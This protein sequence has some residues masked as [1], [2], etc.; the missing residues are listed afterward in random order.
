MVHIIGVDYK[1]PIAKMCCLCFSSKSFEIPIPALGSEP[2]F[3]VTKKRRAQ[4]TADNFFLK[5]PGL[6]VS[7]LDLRIP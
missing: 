5:T 6:E 1:I 7:I 3:L 4:L 2:T